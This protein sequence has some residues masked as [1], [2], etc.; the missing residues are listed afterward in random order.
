MNI[1]NIEGGTH[2]SGFRSA[3]TRSLNNYGKKAEVFK[4]YAPTGDDFREGLTAV[5]SVRVPEP[6]FEGQTK[7]KLGNSEV[8]GIVTSVANDELNRFFE[9]HPSVAKRL[10]QKA[11]SAAEAREAARKAR[12]MV[13]RKGALTSAG[14]PEKLR[15]CR[16]HDLESSELFLVEGDSAGGSADTGRDS[17]T[18]AILPLRGKILNVEKAQLVK[19]L[20]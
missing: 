12:E 15:D 8:E 10:A 1:S 4:D 9:E 6:Q 20:D 3:L 14:L 18:Q 16:T 11:K 17:D 13:R 5:V 7:T 2:L 19:I